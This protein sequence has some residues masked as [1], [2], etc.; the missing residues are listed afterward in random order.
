MQPQSDLI[1]GF[2]LYISLKNTKNPGSSAWNNKHGDLTL[3]NAFYN[4]LEIEADLFKGLT[5]DDLVSYM[6]I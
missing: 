1:Y 6:P 2:N 5:L 3:I 4:L